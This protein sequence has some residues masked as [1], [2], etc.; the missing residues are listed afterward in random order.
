MKGKK[1]TQRSTTRKT[2]LENHFYEIGSLSPNAS[3]TLSGEQPGLAVTAP[4]PRLCWTRRSRRA[5]FLRL[6]FIYSRFCGN[7]GSPTAEE[8]LGRKSRVGTALRHRGSHIPRSPVPRLSRPAPRPLTSCAQHLASCAPP[9]TFCALPV[10]S[11]TPP[12][13]ACAPPLTFCALLRHAQEPQLWLS[14]LG[15]NERGEGGHA[16]RSEVC[17]SPFEKQGCSCWGLVPFSA[18]PC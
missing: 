4:T 3:V 6:N 12:L 15:G 17:G 1:N 11:C 14:E 9:L 10:T 7:A 18:L 16:F 2:A 5:S 13:T 8:Q